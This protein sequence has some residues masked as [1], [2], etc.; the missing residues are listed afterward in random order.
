[1]RWSALESAGFESF[2]EA[3]TGGGYDWNVFGVRLKDGV[4]Y[5]SSDSGCSC[6]GPWDFLDFPQDFEGYGNA[7]DAI[8]A[9]NAWSSGSYRASN[10]ETLLQK[11]L[12]YRPGKGANG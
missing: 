11:L 9:L 6:N 1:M 8:K 2:G 5:W 3:D 12:D 4:F 7:H 10:S